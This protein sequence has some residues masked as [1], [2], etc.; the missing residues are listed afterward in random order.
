M[1]NVIV[2]NIELCLL[3]CHQAVVTPTCGHAGIQGTVIREQHQLLKCRKVEYLKVIQERTRHR[4][5]EA[6][7]VYVLSNS[8]KLCL[9][10]NI[11]SSSSGN[12]YT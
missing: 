1:N 9:I 5:L 10:S 6:V 12:T 8:I 2:N 7:C 3:F 11:L 4:S